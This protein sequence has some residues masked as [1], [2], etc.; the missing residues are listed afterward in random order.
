MR[1]KHKWE[2]PSFSPLSL[3]QIL[4][5][6]ISLI[7]GYFFFRRT[8]NNFLYFLYPV[9]IVFLSFM[10]LWDEAKE[11]AR[12]E[13][14]SET[15]TQY[16]SFF[17]DFYFFSALENSYSLGFQNAFEQLK[18]SKLKDNLK[19]YLEEDNQEHALPFESN[20]L[21]RQEEIV[22]QCSRLYH[23]G[24]DFSKEDCQKIFRLLQQ[25]RNA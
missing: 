14:I 12:Q 13:K 9:G 21:P 10:L 16:L 5:I 23:S 8:D 15:K 11:Y 4:S 17:E 1:N 20:I 18:P 25:A 7:I 2:T 19:E 3:I 6:S 24:E 22:D